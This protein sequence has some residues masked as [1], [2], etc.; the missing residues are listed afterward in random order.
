[1]RKL[2]VFLLTFGLLLSA[3]QSATPTTAP[4]TAP[5][6]GEA[7][8]APAP[9]TEAA[10]QA[11]ASTEETILR[12]SGADLIVI[13]PSRALDYNSSTAT[14]HLYDTLV[15]PNKDAGSDPWLAESWD[16]SSDNLT[17]TFHLRKGVLFHDGS[18]LLASDVVYSYTR[19]ST[20]GQGYFY[21]LPKIDSVKAIDDY[22]VEFKLAKPSGLFIPSLIRLWILNEDL[23]SQNYKPDGQYGTAGDYGMEWLT[24]NDAG[25]GPYA[26]REFP[27]EQYLLMEKNTNWWGEMRSDAPDLFK[28]LTTS[29]AITVRNLFAD[30]ELEISDMWQSLE[31]YQALD[32]IE[33]V[34]IKVSPS[35]L[36]FYYMIN[37]TK[38]PFDDIHCRKAAAYGFDYEQLLTLEW[39]G[40]QLMIGSVPRSLGGWDPNAFT[41]TY[42]LTKAN[43]ELAQCKYANELDKYPITVNWPDAAAF[44]EK[45]ALLFQANM[46]ALGM[47]VNIQALPLLSMEENASTPETTANICSFYVAADLSEAG[48]ML[49]QRYSSATAG[50]WQQTEWLLD[51]ELDAAI[52]DALDTVDVN[53]RYAKYKELQATIAEMSP[54]LFMYEFPYKQAFQTYVDWNPEGNSQLSG[55]N[56]WAPRIGITNP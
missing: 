8:Q 56:V 28:I 44:E 54:S 30:K 2:I 52:Q 20:I 50:T 23:L 3:C 15:F 11:P 4:T 35:V 49:Q 38:A 12:M 25:S 31:N 51:K 37:V 46:A 21:I 34:D 53:E 10:T 27:L 24:T 19:F 16:V 43:D 14:A 17:Y 13:D 29:E 7:T 33:G 9:A 55:Y 45:F 39:P 48:L 47:T 5:V 6:S 22:T 32:A 18:E 40:T 26:V 41:Y 42:D 36:A 1:M